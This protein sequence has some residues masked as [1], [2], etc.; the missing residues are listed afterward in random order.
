MTKQSRELSASA[1]LAVFPRQRE[2][3]TMN[4]SGPV[5]VMHWHARPKL[6][7]V[8]RV[9]DDARDARLAYGK[10]MLHL[11]MVSNDA[12]SMP[13]ADV[14]TEMT[15]HMKEMDENFDGHVLVLGALGFV[16]AALHALA[17]TLALAGSRRPGRTRICRGVDEGVRACVELAAPRAIDESAL[18][19]TLLGLEGLGPGALR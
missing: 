11:V 14:R 19:D 17:S 18:R 6:E 12:L 8:R 10:P 4:V 13:A 9:L 15:L 2:T 16:A 3:V 1:K 5:F 7:D